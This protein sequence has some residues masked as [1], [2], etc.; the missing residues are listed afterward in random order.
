MLFSVVRGV[1]LHQKDWASLK[2]LPLAYWSRGN[3]Q[4]VQANCKFN[5]PLLIA[6]RARALNTQLFLKYFWGLINCWAIGK[7]SFASFLPMLFPANRDVDC[8]IHGK[9]CQTTYKCLPS[10][11][12]ADV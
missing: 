6:W 7:L 3:G 1:K 2:V 5:A 11:F 10:Y 9:K 12:C 8:I 4:L